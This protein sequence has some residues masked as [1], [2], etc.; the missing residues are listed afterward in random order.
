MRASILLATAFAR[1]FGRSYETLLSDL[2]EYAGERS[3]LMQGINVPPTTMNGNSPPSHL[4]SNLH[5]TRRQV[6]LS[7]MLLRDLPLLSE[8]IR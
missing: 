7:T 3:K 4:K 2:R 1:P 6:R 8:H 5:S